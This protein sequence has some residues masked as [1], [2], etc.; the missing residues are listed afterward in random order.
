M[1]GEA[2]RIAGRIAVRASAAHDLPAIAAIYR[3]HVLNGAATFE[4][5]PPDDAEMGRRRE[6][7][8]A[9]ALPHLVAELDGAI[10]GYAYAAPYRPRAAYRY[11]VEDSVYVAPQLSRRGVGRALLEALIDACTAL[12]HRQMVA[13]IGDRANAASI[14]LHAA[15][16]FTRVGTLPNVGFKFGRWIDSV[17]MQRVLG[18]GATT[19][20]RGSA[21][22]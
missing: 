6:E 2:R 4:I 11:T 20:P 12:H 19:P 8:L 14:G 9:R 3:H 17:L 16:G 21:A 1:T 7:T 18:G 15:C 10:A 5:V 13:V 22:T